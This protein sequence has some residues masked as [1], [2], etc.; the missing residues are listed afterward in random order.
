MTIDL[1][2]FDQREHSA[3]ID[4]R[5]L[6]PVFDLQFAQTVRE[7]MRAQG[8]RVPLTDDERFAEAERR[9]RERGE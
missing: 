3:Q 7:K 5:L 1:R 6:Q 8:L 4:R 2:D 9:M